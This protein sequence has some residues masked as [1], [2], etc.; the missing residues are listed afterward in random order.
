MSLHETGHLVWI[1]AFKPK[2]QAMSFT[3]TYVA[4]IHASQTLT[5]IFHFWLVRVA[6][7]F[8]HESS[9][10]TLARLNY[11]CVPIWMIVC[12]AQLSTRLFR[13]SLP[14]LLL[15]SEFRMVNCTEGSH[16]VLM[17]HS[18]VLKWALV[19]C[20]T[21]GNAQYCCQRCDS[22]WLVLP[23]PA[24]ATNSAQTAGVG[25]TTTERS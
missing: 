12:V 24:D 15:L 5:L 22:R 13:S 23:F 25:E 9:W 18:H 19:G 14:R 11:M 17:R 6:R 3:R 16:L 2:G 21:V 1:Q 10:C 20:C 4:A 8:V 7:T